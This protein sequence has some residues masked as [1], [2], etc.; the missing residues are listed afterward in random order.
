[1]QDIARALKKCDDAVAART[2]HLESICAEWNEH[3]ARPSPA[4]VAAGVSA[5]ATGPAA[6]ARRILALAA[7]LDASR[8]AAAS[9]AAAAERES[10]D[11]RATLRDGARAAREQAAAEIAALKAA[12]DAAL[13]SETAR[14]A[15]VEE[16]LASFRAR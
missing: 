2:A 1:V 7:A 16:E 14:R 15:A 12:A 5:D 11:L 8:M 3:F 13:A 4:L 10:A 9:E 6:L